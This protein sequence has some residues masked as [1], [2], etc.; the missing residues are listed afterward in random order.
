M[1]THQ[2]ISHGRR[3]IGFG[4]DWFTLEEGQ[5]PGREGRN[6][7]KRA[8]EDRDI[9]VERHGE[10]PQFALASSGDGAKAGAVAAAAMVADT[11]PGES[12]LY[13]LE[14]GQFVWICCGR[15]GFILPDGDRVFGTRQ[16]AYRAF[17]DLQ[18]ETF[19]HIAIP[20][21]WASDKT[22]TDLGG[23]TEDITYTSAR[24]FAALD[25]PRWG[26][27]RKL[28]PVQAIVT[29]SVAVTVV[30]VIGFAA[31]S[32]Y[33]ARNAYEPD[34]DAASARIKARFE[35]RERER[36][37]QYARFDAERPW[38]ERPPA[39]ARITACLS[40][41]GA[42]PRQAAGYVLAQATCRGSSVVARMNNDDG[43][44][45]WLNEWSEAHP[46]IAV[47]LS[48]NG[49][50]ADLVRSVA[51]LDA[52]GAQPLD[53]DRTF[54]DLA[55]V[56]FEAAQIDG[57]SLDM[58]QPEVAERTDYPDYV[59]KFATATFTL[60][61][62]RPRLWPDV[63]TDMPGVVITTITYAAENE[64]YTIEGRLHVPNI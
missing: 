5:K 15:A 7:A 51:S 19:K 63:F 18:P 42:I 20:E 2:T 49:E 22:Q 53:A 29:S 55:R 14:L 3:T 41:I 9:I 62:S 4:M 64:T 61:T 47:S 38:T 21:S 32:A 34:P 25:M 17:Q 24:K 57:A 13:V 45:R 39:G 23:E 11:H 58:G 44:A 37:E 43:Y 6:L 12:W 28:S 36:E 60:Q 30:A 27:M 59:P 50:A 46:D 56:L 10:Q 35:Q 40:Q 26:R 54:P 1:P 48:I 16:E 33:D 52:R 31:Y 8:M